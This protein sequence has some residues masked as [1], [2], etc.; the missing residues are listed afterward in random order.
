MKN[1]ILPTLPATLHGNA[2]VDD[3]SVNV[4]QAT[5]TLAKNF[6]LNSVK[7][8]AIY[9]TPEV[10]SLQ[11]QIEDTFMRCAVATKT[12]ITGLASAYVTNSVSSRNPSA[13]DA[14]T[15]TLS[16]EKDP[17]IVTTQN[18]HIPWWESVVGA[19]TLGIMNVVIEAISLAIE[20]A[21]GGADASTT[22]SHFGQVAP[23]LVSWSGQ[24]NVTITHGGLEDN[25][26]MQG[27]LKTS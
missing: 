25:I 14:A 1:V 23:G 10:T 20:N 13:F 12:N 26:Y 21:V 3:F 4:G 19:L 5:I 17:H 24:E 27:A 18:T 2:R 15:R 8:G 22:A 11:F 9:Y 7:V 16:F 6:N